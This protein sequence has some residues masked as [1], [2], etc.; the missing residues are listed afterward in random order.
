MKCSTCGNTGAYDVMNTIICPEC[1]ERLVYDTATD[2]SVISA[3]F[4]RFYAFGLRVSNVGSRII[5]AS[6]V[7]CFAILFLAKGLGDR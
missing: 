6:I 5:G 3:A 1:A 2:K 7:I 4:R